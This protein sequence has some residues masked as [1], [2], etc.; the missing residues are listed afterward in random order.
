MLLGLEK[1][2]QG[3]FWGDALPAESNKKPIR[4]L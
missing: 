4:I 2:K 1:I 3:S